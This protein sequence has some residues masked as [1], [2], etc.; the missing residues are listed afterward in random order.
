MQ[1]IHTSRAFGPGSA[2]CSRRLR[3]ALAPAGVVAAVILAGCGAGAPARQST[4]PANPATRPSRVH[5]SSA[6]RAQEQAIHAQ[7]LASLHQLNDNNVR[8]GSAAGYLPRTTVAVNRVVTATAAHP[9]LAIEG[10]AVEV[11]PP[12]ARALATAV[13]PNVPD[14]IQGTSA[15]QTPATFEL[16]FARVHGS[17]PLDPEAFTIVDERGDVHHPRLRVSGGGPLPAT[18]PTGAPFT[19]VLSATL[20]I[21]SGALRYAPVGT[22]D[23]VAWDF[24]VETD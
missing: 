14:R 21:G 18:V 4:V 7:V 10:V 3:S 12:G 2:R 15:P 1:R 17:I 23:L 20:P 16:T 8:Y 6:L 11:A 5:I 9:A 13:G 24:D 22:H 19:L